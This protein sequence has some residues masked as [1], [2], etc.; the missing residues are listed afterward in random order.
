MYTFR[1]SE[2]SEIY[3]PSEGIEVWTI[4]GEFRGVFSLLDIINWFC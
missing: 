3:G 4:D 1:V 2:D